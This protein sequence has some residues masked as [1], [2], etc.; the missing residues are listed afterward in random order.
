MPTESAFFLAG[1]L[2]LAAALGYV[3]ARLGE[4]DDPSRPA[5]GEYLRGLKFLLKEQPDRAV[6]AFTR[7][8]DIDE[9]SLETHF[10][11]GQLFRRRGEVERAIRVHRDL[12]E[13][14]SLN[15]DQ[16]EDARFALAEDY[17]SAGLF[18]R[19]EA[20]LN[21]LHDSP[22]YRRQAL[23]QMIRLSEMTREWERAIEL[24]NDLERTDRGTARPGAV[25]HYWCE[26][27]EQARREGN[28]AKAAEYLRAAEQNGSET[29][30]VAFLHGGLAE[31]AGDAAMAV[32]QY[33]KVAQ[34]EPALL[35]DV[36]PRLWS[37][38]RS[39]GRTAEFAEFAAQLVEQNPAVSK[40]LALA[41]I[42]DPS[43]DDDLVIR[44]FTDLLANDRTLRSLVDLDRIRAGS[45]VERTAGLERLRL[46]LRDVALK[47]RTY[48]CYECGYT[49]LS[50]QW[51]CPGCR[52][53]DTVRPQVRLIF[54]ASDK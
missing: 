9:E 53:W 4:E 13:R 17:L 44:C 39:A 14:P 49:S 35:L 54:E 34:R 50:L 26:L 38:S 51:Q 30:R 48:R 3:F 36:L 29:V 31:D 24:H 52:A 1:L 16:Q 40:A 8:T 23:T 41:A 6:E 28:R 2:F 19:A 47:G 15:R 7:A 20:L 11:L 12:M 43:I 18:D 42:L 22:R 25:G 27:A 21:D 5:V 37:V 45:P 32:A 10:A 33:R 46:A